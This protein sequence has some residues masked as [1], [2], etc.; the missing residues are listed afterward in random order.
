DTIHRGDGRGLGAPDMVEQLLRAPD[1]GLWAATSA[2]LLRWNDGERR[3]EP[4]PGAGGDAVYGV[5]VGPDGTVWLAG[6]GRLSAYAWDGASLEHLRTIGAVQGMPMVAP[7][8]VIVDEAGVVWLTTVRGL[9]RF[10]A[11]TGRLRVYG[12]HDGLPSH[13]FSEFPIA[14]SARGHVA[15][16]TAD[17]LLL[18]HPRRVQWSGHAPTLAIESVDLRRGDGRVALAPQP[19]LS[20]RHDD[21]G[22]RVV[23]RLLSFTD[24]HAHRYRFR[25][26]GYDPGWVDTGS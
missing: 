9:V 11:D 26:E 21:R 5:A 16:G 25:L 6:L 22:L 17:G 7:G 24:A 10:D 15:A 23:A 3:L 2:G 19:E 8:G 1:G 20:L 18:F 13:E 14:V 12:V 4:V